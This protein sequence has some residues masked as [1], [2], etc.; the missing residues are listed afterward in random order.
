MTTFDD[1]QAASKMRDLVVR[2]TTKVIS[3]ERPL[4]RLGM[5]YSSDRKAS[6]AEI[7]FPGESEMNLVRVRFGLN[8]SPT[9]TVNSHGKDAADVVRIEGR[10]GSYYITGFVRGV[11]HDSIPVG[12]LIEFAGTTIPPGYLPCDG[13]VRPNDTFPSLFDE[14]GYLYGG[15]GTSTFAVPTRAGSG[16]TQ[17]LIK[18]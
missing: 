3:R 2:I 5:V 1:L 8:L 12:A 11:P 10:P 6:T 18:S 4:P 13:T 14:I 7:L 16:G 15:D 17:F 9:R